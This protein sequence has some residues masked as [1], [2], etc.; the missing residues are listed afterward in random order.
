MNTI[1]KIKIHKNLKLKNTNKN[2]YP[3]K[4]QSMI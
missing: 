2:K 3:I 4:Y 1:N